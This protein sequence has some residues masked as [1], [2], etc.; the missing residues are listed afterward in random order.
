MLGTMQDFPLTIN[1][2]FQHGAK[3]YGNSEVVTFLDDKSH[4]ATFAEVAARAGR[5]AGALKRG[6]SGRVPLWR[7]RVSPQRRLRSVSP[8]GAF[9]SG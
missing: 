8:A 7:V 5:L 2:L 3:I 9:V 4:R 1:F 6:C